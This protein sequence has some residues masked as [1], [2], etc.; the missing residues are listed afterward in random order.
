MWRGSEYASKCN[1]RRILNIP[2][3]QLC[4]VFAYVNVAQGSEYD[5]IWLNNAIWQGSEFAWSTFHRVLNKPQ[6]LNMSGLR[7]WQGCEYARVT[8]GVEYV[9]MS[10]NMPQYS[11][12]MR[13]YALIRLDMI[14]YTGIYLKKQST[15]YPRIILNV[16]DT[17]RNIRSL[18]KLLSSYPDK[19][20]FI[21]LS[22]I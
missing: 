12:S 18:F 3:I 10:Q 17:V 5:W 14:E 22:N 11:P 4:Q 6:V 7:I 9:W 20:L 2:G 1:Y 15:E 21:A 19:H 13:E 8:Q 16:S